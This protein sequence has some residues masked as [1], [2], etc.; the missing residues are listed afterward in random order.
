MQDALDPR[1]Q[2]GDAWWHAS[3]RFAAELLSLSR[4]TNGDPG[5]SARSPRSLLSA[6]RLTVALGLGL[7]LVGH[8]PP[9]TIVLLASVLV[10]VLLLFEAQIYRRETAMQAK[11]ELIESGVFASLLWPENSAEQE[12]WKD[13]VVG[14]LRERTRP[15]PLRVA[16]GERL[17]GI[18][19]W[20]YLA[21]LLTSLGRLVIRLITYHSLSRVFPDS[22]IGPVPRWSIILACL[23]I[24][25]AAAI[26]AYGWP[27]CRWR[28]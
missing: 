14:E 18:Y 5:L 1:D 22:A 2:G 4:L 10:S 13:L 24:N 21:L 23:F 19:G 15:L 20:I 3:P 25:G 11:H 9:I 8:W 7:A 28:D 16:L 6:C 27:R 17:Q 12:G 26:L